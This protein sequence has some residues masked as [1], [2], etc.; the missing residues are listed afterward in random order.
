MVLS[1][2][3]IAI[4]IQWNEKKH[5]VFL[6]KWV[7]GKLN[8]RMFL[9]FNFQF[10]LQRIICNF[11]E[12]LKMS[13]VVIKS[14]WLSLFLSIFYVSSPLLS[15]PPSIILPHHFCFVFVFTFLFFRFFPML[16]F[17]NF[18]ISFVLLGP[19]VFTYHYYSFKS[20]VLL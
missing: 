13:A 20:G 11:I 10:C 8:D 9:G 7:L 17:S 5:F 18:F 6:F 2:L 19:F 3:I 16:S 15:L 4:T 12:K 1:F 14:Y